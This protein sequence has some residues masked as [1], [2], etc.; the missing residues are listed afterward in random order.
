MDSFQILVFGSLL[1]FIF[2]LFVNIKK[3]NLKELKKYKLSYFLKIFGIGI[4]GTFCYN[5]FLYLGIDRIGANNGFI[6]NYLWPIMIVIF[7]WMILKEKMNLKKIVAILLSFTGVVVMV[8]GNGINLR[9]VE[10]L[11]V[12]F[13]IIAAISYGLFSVLTKRVIYDKYLSMML[14]YFVAFVA[15][16]LFALVNNKLILPSFEQG[17]GLIWIGIFT[18]AIAWT[19]WSL[20]IG[21]GDTSK[22]ANLAYITPFLS[23]IWTSIFLKEQ[24]TLYALFGLILIVSGALL[25]LSDSKKND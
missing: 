4:L 7:A 19:S 23:L 14:Y 17:L 2:L 15:A 6:L 3:K 25:Q 20:A 1:A 21:K 13:C 10:F 24:L 16:L 18:S 9:S 5:L 8:L 11:G 22:I 12:L